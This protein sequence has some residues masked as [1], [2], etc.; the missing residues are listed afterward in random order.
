MAQTSYDYDPAVAYA[1]VIA[2]LAQSYVRSGRNE[3]TSSIPFGVAV[4]KGTGDGDIKLPAAGTDDV[5]GIVVHDHA[6][7]SYAADGTPDGVETKGSAGVLVSGPAYVK[8]EE[9]V[10]AG[11]DVY[12]RF[13]NSVDNTR[14]Q[15][16]AFRKTV[17]GGTALRLRG[18]R[19]LTS[20]AKDGFAVVW[21]DA[22]AN[23]SLA[24]DT[25][26]IEDDAVTTAKIADD[27]VTAAQLADNA[28][29]SAA[30]KDGA[31]IAAKFGA[32]SVETAAIKDLNVT[33]GKLAANAVAVGKLAVADANGLAP[34]LVINKAIAAGVG[35][36]ADD[37]D[38]GVPGLKAR[39]LDTFVIVKTAAGGGSTGTVRT[40][41]GAGGDALSDG[42]SI[43]ATGVARNAALT[44]PKDIAEDTHLYLRRSDN[45]AALTVVMLLAPIA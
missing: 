35:A 4:K 43:A 2:D 28:V 8:V 24:V 14:T 11:D 45:T 36:G 3:E 19:Y 17:D 16:G 5:F 21:F 9:A 15:K 31:V 41:T 10:A 13:A 34:L 33:T 30:I 1:G 20:A 7:D 25:T 40:A 27:A 37:V 42:L 38:L 22:I 32:Q 6:H 23:R 44:E 18:A 26:E 39:V 29:E 12:V